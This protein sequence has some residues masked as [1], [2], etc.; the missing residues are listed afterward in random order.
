[1]REVRLWRRV[2]GLGSDTVIEGV[3]WDAER[4]ALVV[5]VRPRRNAQLRC[6]RCGTPS[7]RYDQGDGR[8]E[9]RA[10]DVG[11]V[12]AYLEGDAPRVACPEHGPTVAGLPWA[13]HGA[14]QVRWFEDQ[15]AWLA[16]HTSKTAVV[17]LMRVAW[18]TV[19]SI[20]A[21]VVAEGRAARDPFDGL[22]RIGIDEIS[23]K[24]GHRYLMVVV[25][26]DTGRLVWAAAG[27]DK[28]TLA[29]FF[30]ALGEDRCAQM[31]LVSADALEW[32][33]EMVRERCK[34][35][36]LCLDAFHIVKWATEALDEVRRQVWNEARRSGQKALAKDLKGARFALWKNP[37]DLTARQGAKLAWIAVT[38]KRLY[39]AYLLKEQLRQVFALKGDAGIALLKRWLAWASRSQLPAFVA[40]ARRIRKNLVG[41]HATLTEQLSN[42][43]VEST[44]TKLRVLT[45]MA[46]GFK[47][48][49][50]LI[51]LAL[52]DRGG[53]CP[54]LP[55]RTTT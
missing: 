6:G 52:L 3:D 36:T 53:Y 47:K 9:W 32:I 22:R 48:P 21:R 11:E 44:N 23:Y 26:H 4:D 54:A 33:G 37:E 10:M 43:L 5:S 8:R 29:A 51:A 14:R 19:G 27:H 41:I 35:A 28:D 39:R 25:D 2:F 30:D 34:R 17:A 50:H 46:Y 7:P 18:R 13:R 31:R 1:M 38:N 20:V 16:V 40:L 15:V 24:K 49:E 12:K 55:G 42:A 45:R